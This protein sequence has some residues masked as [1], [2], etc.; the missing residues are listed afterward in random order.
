LPGLNRYCKAYKEFFA[1]AGERLMG[2]AEAIS[3]GNAGG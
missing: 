1:Y 2:M 3:G